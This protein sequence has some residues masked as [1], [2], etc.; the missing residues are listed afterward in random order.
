MVHDSML[1][2]SMAPVS[3]VILR[4][5]NL[6][7][8]DSIRSYV[9]AHILRFLMRIG[10]FLHH[11]APP[12]TPPPSFVIKA[13]T[14]LSEQDDNIRLVFY[15]PDGY[16]TAPDNYRY[17]V[18]INFHGGGFTVGT[19]TDDARFA[20][21]VLENVKAVFV[22]VEY[23]LAP[24]HPFSVGPEDG[25][26]AL[27]YLAAHADDLRLD[28]HQITLC[29]FSAGANLALTV[30]F[31]L[32][33][34]QN[35]KGKRVLGRN[36]LSSPS[37]TNTPR[38]FREEYSRSTLS[39]PLL[40]SLQS[41]NLETSQQ[42]P[43]LTICAI[44]SFYPLTDFRISRA[45]KCASNPRPE[46]NLPSTLT[47]L[48]DDSYF[49]PAYTTTQLDLSDPYLSPAAATNE[50]LKA[51]YPQL[52]ILYTCEYDM[53]NKEGIAF[54]ERLKSQGKTVKGGLIKKVPHGFDKMPNPMKYPDVA[55]RCYA[56]ACAE[57]NAAALGRRE[58]VADRTQLSRAK[59]VA[60]FGEV[61]QDDNGDWSI[62]AD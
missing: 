29:G 31:M 49:S 44:I 11:R 18:I 42:I 8:D 22:S 51:A 52:I 15:V 27:I 45:A 1:Q 55:E 19:G 16:H 58:S 35:G 20:R 33:D 38:S 3:C 9:K 40:Q 4:H 23:R 32:H 36:H 61:S 43:P 26:D 54:S 57:L 56:E 25:T 5:F 24:E 48:F 62:T 7:A 39:I 59:D 2:P 10:M 37:G 14:R 13:P 12:A 46:F 50:L 34:L 30:P 28:P 6:P 53:L 21:S 41:T 17:P 47:N 60:R